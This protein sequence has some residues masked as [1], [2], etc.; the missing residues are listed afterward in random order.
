MTAFIEKS[1]RV[2]YIPRVMAQM[3]ATMRLDANNYVI[4]TGEQGSGRRTLAKEMLIKYMYD[5]YTPAIANDT[6]LL[7]YMVG[8]ET[9]YVVMF[10]TYEL[11][12][13]SEDE[14]KFYTETLTAVKNASN[15]KVVVVIK[16]GEQQRL[17]EAST[18]D[19]GDVID[20]SSKQYQMKP[21]ERKELFKKHCKAKGIEICR[22]KEEENLVLNGG[23]IYQGTMDEILR[24]DIGKG[25][26]KACDM[27]FNNEKAFQRG[28]DHFSN[29]K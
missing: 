8:A 17:L 16:L 15:I 18:V 2:I 29:I 25:F 22:T 7:Q 5:N 3:H 26:S 1:K 6:M 21:Q 10:E 19:A 4:V 27:F 28:L 20:L 23:K 9:K 13:G 14:K 24:L 12:P 11:N